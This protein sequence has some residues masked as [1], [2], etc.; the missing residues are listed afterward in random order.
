MTP[1]PTIPDLDALEAAEAKAQTRKLYAFGCYLADAPSNGCAP[2]PDASE[3]TAC[4]DTP[5]NAALACAAVN[6]LPGLLEMARR[7]LAAEAECGRLREWQ[8]AAQQES[9]AT[10]ATYAKD[11][12]AQYDKVTK[13]RAEI[14]HIKRTW[15]PCR[16]DG[17]PG[18]EE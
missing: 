6:A 5:E 7:T 11:L 17:D 16:V 12:K 14:E 3:P 2:G 9:I 4:F 1:D 18:Q 13:L 15:S 10:L 8:H